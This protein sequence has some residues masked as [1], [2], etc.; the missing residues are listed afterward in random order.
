M[1]IRDR[2]SKGEALGI[3]ISTTEDSITA[4]ASLTH[5]FINFEEPCYDTVNLKPRS[6]FDIVYDEDEGNSSKCAARSN[7]FMGRCPVFTEDLKFNYSEVP[8]YIGK[9]SFE[10]HNYL[11][12]FVR[13]SEKL[14]K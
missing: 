1:C 10:L 6:Y 9:N 2:S 4:C 3:S 12:Q 11:L 5:R 13:A 8:C 14:K 7:Y